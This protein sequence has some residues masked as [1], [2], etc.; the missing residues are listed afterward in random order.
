MF[1]TIEIC[2]KFVIIG[3]ELLQSLKMYITHNQIHVEVVFMVAMIAI[4]RRSSSS[5]CTRSPALP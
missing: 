5:I 3:I 1:K 2:E 4:A